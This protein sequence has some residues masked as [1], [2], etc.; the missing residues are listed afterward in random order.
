[1]NR[2]LTMFSISSLLGVLGLSV[3]EDT[4]VTSM[5]RGEAKGRRSHRSDGELAMRT[6]IA[7]ARE[8][9]HLVTLNI[10]A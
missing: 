3:L 5:D 10:G 9:A 8:V 6:S 2:E 7:G 4:N 1:M